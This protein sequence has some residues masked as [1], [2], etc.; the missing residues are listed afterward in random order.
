MPTK[1][2]NSDTIATEIRHAI[3]TEILMRLL[4]RP[5]LMKRA[6]AQVPPEDLIGTAK[7]TFQQLLLKTINELIQQCDFIL[8]NAPETDSRISKSSRGQGIFNLQNDL[9]AIDE[10]QL[11]NKNSFT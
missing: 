8:K 5:H 6:T 10:N 3:V 7:P 2:Q 4:Q 1:K 9:A 11:T